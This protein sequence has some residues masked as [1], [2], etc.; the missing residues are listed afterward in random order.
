MKDVAARAGV[1][2]GTVSNVINRPE[3]V[4]E[5]TRTRV[6]AAIAALGFVR[7][8][9]ARQLRG[10]GSRTLAYVVLDASNPFFT[11]VARGVQEAADA[12]GLAVYLCDSRQDTARQDAY[13]DL[14][15]QQ[16]VEGVLVTP[17]GTDEERIRQLAGRGTPVVLVDRSSGPGAC[18]VAVDD[19]LGGDLAVTH[20]LELGHRRIIFVGGPDTLSQVRD[21]VTGAR[22]A[23]GRAGRDPGDLVVL[24]TQALDFA[25]GREAA[26]RLAAIP[27]RDRPTA[28]FCVNDLVA[29]GLLQQT[30][31][32]GYRV[33]E[34]LAIV[35]YDDIEFAEAASVPLTSV[36]QPRHLLGRTA[37]ELLLDEAGGLSHEHRQVVF[38]PELV[39]RASTQRGR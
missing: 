8:E 37:A 27:A 28:A 1:S 38:E 14:L 2:L 34:D 13:L 11:D 29:L 24:H 23:L 3:R 9:S 15:E 33:P 35:G 4:S 7:N 16:R 18:S 19:V 6:L 20:L 25:A 21:R 10:G 36:S 22:R 32:M 12:A 31:R 5:Q 26:E 39:V 30:V 17:V